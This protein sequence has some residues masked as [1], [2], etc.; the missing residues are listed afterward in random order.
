MPYVGAILSTIGGGCQPS[1]QVLQ[2]TTA[3]KSAA[4]T[5]HPTAH[6]RRRPRRHPGCRN[7]PRAPNPADEAIP[8][9]PLP[10]MGGTSMPTTNHT[11]SARANDQD[12]RSPM[13]LISP[14][15]MMSSSPSRLPFNMSSSSSTNSKGRFLDFFRDVDKPV[16]PRKRSQQHHRS[17]RTGRRHGPRAP[18]LQEHLLSGR[19]HRPRVP[20]QSTCHGW[21]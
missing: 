10:S 6:Q 5:R 20:N 11:K 8:S 15:S 18:D 14:F 21:E 17:R 13:S 7:V 1:S 12:P 4:I 3:N 16:P 19:R 2:S 9:H